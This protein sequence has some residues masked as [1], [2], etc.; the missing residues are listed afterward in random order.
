MNKVKNACKNSKNVRVLPLDLEDYSDFSLKVLQAI[1]FFNT[2]DILF[3][4]AGIS[5]RSLAKE[6]LIRVDKRIMDINYFGTVA[7]TKELLPYFI[8]KNMGHFVIITSIV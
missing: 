3:N 8:E 5:Q 4:N 1:S 2:I 6:T 7:L